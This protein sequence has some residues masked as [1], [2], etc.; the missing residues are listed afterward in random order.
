MA[1]GLEGCALLLA[2]V[3]EPHH[4]ARENQRMLGHQVGNL[5]A[6]FLVQCF[7]GGRA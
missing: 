4:A 6:G 2:E 3:G 5:V 1:H 7:I